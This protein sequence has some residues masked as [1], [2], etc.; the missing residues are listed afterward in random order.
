MVVFFL[1]TNASSTYGAYSS[2]IFASQVP[3]LQ[4]SERRETIMEKNNK[5][6]MTDFY[7]LTM[8]QTYFDAGK[9]GNAASIEQISVQPPANIT[10][11]KFFIFLSVEKN[12]RN[13]KIVNRCWHG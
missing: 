7:E 11:F 6:M 8:A 12:R 2:I 3:S 5:T 1:N 9:V 4:C 10:F 13:W